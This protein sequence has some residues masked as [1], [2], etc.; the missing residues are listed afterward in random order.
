MG[1]SLAKTVYAYSH[2]LIDIQNGSYQIHIRESRSLWKNSKMQMVLTGYDIQYTTQKA[3]KGSV[4]VEHL[5]HQ[6]MDDY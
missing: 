4:L 2:Y 6:A 1:C 5:A 3:I